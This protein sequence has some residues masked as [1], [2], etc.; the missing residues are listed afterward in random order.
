MD[1]RTVIHQIAAL[2][3]G[4]LVGADL[5]VSCVPNV[6]NGH[7]LIGQ[8]HI[9]LL[10]EIGETIL[11]QTDTPG[12]KAADVGKFML[13][14]VQDC[15]SSD[16]QIIF[17]EGIGQVE[18]ASKQHYGK[19]FMQL[20]PHQRETLLLEIDREQEAYMKQKQ[21]KDPAHYFR[22]IKELTLLGYFTSEVGATQALRYVPVPRKFEGDIP[23]SKGDRGWA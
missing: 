20:D 9:A 2:L 5:L 15:Y 16:N 1:R 12:A 11:P 6:R 10:N 17:Y 19:R 14:M 3:G 23:Y 18:Q 22:M 4:T 8:E 7:A 21:P 13:L